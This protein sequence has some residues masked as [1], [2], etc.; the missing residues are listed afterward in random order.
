MKVIKLDGKCDLYA[1]KM[2]AAPMFPKDITGDAIASQ[3]PG[4][5][6]IDLMN[7]G[8]LPNIYK[9]ANVEKTREFEL[10]DWWYVKEF[11]IDSLVDDTE[12]FLVFD[13][14]CKI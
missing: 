12:A 6:E 2:G 14:V 11:E 13:G 4:N 7:A 5:V 3:I 10:Y 1:Y 8:I 9:D